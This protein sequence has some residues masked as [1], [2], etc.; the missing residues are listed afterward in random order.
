MPGWWLVKQDSSL[1][2]KY[3]AF[4]DVRQNIPTLGK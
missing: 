4:G 2:G 3:G 1:V